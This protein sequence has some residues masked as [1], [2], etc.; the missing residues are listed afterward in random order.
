MSDMDG[1][2][3]DEMRN[4]LQELQMQAN[5]V[6]DEVSHNIVIYVITV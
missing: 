4:E 2:T 3:E 5:A 1:K 6:T